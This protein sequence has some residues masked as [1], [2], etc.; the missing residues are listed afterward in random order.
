MT[1]KDLPI[2]ATSTKLKAQ[3][4]QFEKVI[5]LFAFSHYMYM[6]FQDKK[7]PCSLKLDILKGTRKGV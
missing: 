1:W 3:V 2:A 4:N 7:C 6:L 5:S